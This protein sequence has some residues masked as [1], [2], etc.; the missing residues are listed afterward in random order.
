MTSAPKVILV[1]GASSGFGA[2]T[3]RK[4][5]LAGYIVYASMQATETRNIPAV[6]AAGEFS[7]EKNVTL[8][9]VELNVTD[10]TSVNAA[11][12]SI[13]QESGR[14]DVV[15]HNAGHMCYGPAESFTA[16]QLSAYYDVNTIGAHRVN[17]AALPHMRCAGSGLLV[18]VGSSSTSGGTPPF[19]APYF[20]AKAAM[21]SLA[22]SYASELSKWGIQTCIVSPG[23]YTSG[24]N[25]FA[26][27]GK[28]ENA[29]IEKE[30]FEGPYKGVP[31]RIMEGLRRLEPP[32]ADV[33]EVATA[34]VTVVNSEV[35]KR[36]FRVS[37]D[38]SK[39]GSVLV[40]QLKNL[41]R[42]DVYQRLGLQDLRVN[43]DN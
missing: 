15:V 23:A 34:I 2:L 5:A 11:I 38:P 28:G 37:I 42:R 12:A 43:E 6:K 32:D 17:L 9:T 8:R 1:T 3:A 33:G 14:L 25:H 20:A 19:L 36:P 21:D 41:V 4:L 18:W 35:E 26:S 30:Y 13:I 10:T 24:T 7:K 16:E 40:D 27:A 29:N 39:D 22:V 31:E